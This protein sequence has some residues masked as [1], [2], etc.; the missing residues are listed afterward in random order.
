MKK[1][2][3]RI[4]AVLLTALVAFSCVSCKDDEESPVD[5]GNQTAQTGNHVFESKDTDKYVVQNGKTEYKLVYPSGTTTAEIATALDEF[6][7][8][9]EKATGVKLGKTT[10]AGLTHNANNKYISLGDTTL[11]ASSGLEVD[12][13]KLGLEG[14]RILTK[15]QTVFIVGNTDRGTLYGVY[16]FLE[17]NFNF[18]CYTDRVYT[19]DQVDSFKLKEYAITDIPDFPERTYHL[20]YI[21]NSPVFDEYDRNQYRVRM[22]LESDHYRYIPVWKEYNKTGGSSSTENSTVSVLPYEQFYAEHPD[23]YSDASGNV[24]YKA[25]LC[26]TAHGNKEEYKW[27][28][29]ESFNKLKW[30]IEN[31]FM[32][33]R[34]KYATT[35][36]M[37]IADNNNQCTCEH[38]GAVTKKYGAVV[39]S[40]IL[41]IN[42]LADKL[43]AWQ[44]SLSKDDPAYVEGLLLE[45]AAYGWCTPAPV[46]KNAEGKW[47]PT[48]PEMMLRDNVSVKIAYINSSTQRSMFDPEAPNFVNQV[49][50]WGVLGGAGIFYFL[51]NLNYA[52]DVY[53]YD[54]YNFYS[55]EG[56]RFL[57]DSGQVGIIVDGYGRG[58]ALTGWYSLKVYLDSKMYWNSDLDVPTLVDKW[59]KGVYKDVAPQMK[60]VFMQTRLHTLSYQ[61][62]FGLNVTGKTCQVPI[63][64][65]DFYPLPV[66]NSWLAGYDLALAMAEKYKYADPETYELIC[67]Y[68][69]QEALSPLIAKARIYY[70][71]LAAADRQSLRDRLLYDVEWLDAAGCKLDEFATEFLGDW[72]KTL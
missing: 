14:S 29:E 59:F 68:I 46:K 43:K 17:Y 38:C 31:R 6:T 26:Y 23:C 36:Q 41:F 66:L 39:A 2:L 5:N 12:K 57:R 54:S 37:M 34:F 21:N 67:R 28:L 1:L 25:Q 15:D 3:K 18:D 63:E 70:N 51:Y 24:G 35:I 69:E 22:R 9:F 58:F 62:R 48:A 13:A 55:T 53:F 10:D 4:S 11:F 72:V 30:S 33:G 44:D 71:E 61:E 27:M 50:S 8:F 49:D 60:E 65:K 16:T 52:N 42:E 47:E 56:Y 7:Y 64:K 20:S 32:T 19:I 40:Q 45:F